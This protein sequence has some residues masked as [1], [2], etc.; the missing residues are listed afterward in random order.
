MTKK[1]NITTAFV[2][3]LINEMLDGNKYNGD[4]FYRDQKLT[5]FGVKQQRSKVSYIAE[6]K[7]NGKNYRKVIGN[8]LVISN[9]QAREKA[10]KFLGDMAVGI[11]VIE[12]EKENKFKTITLEQAFHDYLASRKREEKTVEEYKRIMNNYFNTWLKKPLTNIT[13]DM[14]EQLYQSK[15]ETPYMANRIITLLSAIYNYAMVKYKKGNKRIIT[16][17]PCLIIRTIDKYQELVSQ[18]K[19]EIYDI[20]KFWSATEPNICD[21]L[22]MA[23]TKILCR[24]CILMGCREQE[25]CT[26]KRENIIDTY[27]VLKI[28]ETKND[29]PHTIPYGTYAQTIINKLCEGRSD[30]DYLFPAHTKSGHLEGHSKYIK[31][32]CDTAGIKF[33]LK[34]L[35]H[36]FTTYAALHLKIDNCLVNVM[37]NHKNNDV[38]YDSYVT[39]GTPD[40]DKYRESFQKVEDFILEQAKL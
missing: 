6:I 2:K 31:K 37:T 38:T 29:R 22:K 40:F 32:I 20:L 33:C 3:E 39:I 26:L 23:Q 34:D 21:T 28:P 7:V 16:N 11:N 13:D 8:A 9:S 12:L 35:R 36:S 17:N 19:V 10:K 15:K 18:T 30:N 14:V 24:L 25:I 5:G 27:N 1:V 4:V